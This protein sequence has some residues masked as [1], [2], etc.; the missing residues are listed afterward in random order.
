MAW[1]GPDLQLHPWPHPADALARDTALG[2]KICGLDASDPHCAALKLAWG[3]LLA[4]FGPESAQGGCVGGWWLHC[5]SCDAMQ[6]HH[7]C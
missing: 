4:Q 7:E 5:F 2:A 6:H 3:V 1:H